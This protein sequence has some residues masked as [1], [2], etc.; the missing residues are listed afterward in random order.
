MA[1]GEGVGEGGGANAGV[2]ESRRLN[3]GAS[4]DSPHPTQN[5][6]TSENIRYR[7]GAVGIILI[8]W[9]PASLGKSW[10]H[11]APPLQHDLAEGPLK[12]QRQQDRADR[13]A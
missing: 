1:V 13:V 10:N 2:G 8:I 11:T 12:A 3:A 4:S 6:T 5:S 7:N 9:Q